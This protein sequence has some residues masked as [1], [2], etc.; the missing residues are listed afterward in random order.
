MPKPRLLV[1]SRM[2]PAL[3]ARTR[4]LCEALTSSWAVL[5]IAERAALGEGDR[6]K[7][8]GFP[9]LNVDIWFKEKR[10][11]VLT[12]LL[13]VLQLNVCALRVA[14]RWRCEVIVCND[15]PYS[16]AG[17]LAKWLLK[18]ELVY[19][20]HEILWGTNCHRVWL[21]LF[22]LLERVVLWNSTFWMA[23][24][25]ARRDLVMAK[26]KVHV[27]CV[28]YENYPVF[29][30]CDE[31][32]RS[33]IPAILRDKGKRSEWVVILQGTLLPDRGIEELL[34]ACEGSDFSVVL[35]GPGPLRSRLKAM[36]HARVALLPACPNEEAVQWFKEA[37]LAFVYYK[38][39]C[40]NSAYACSSKLYC[41][42]FAEVPVVCN[43]LPAFRAFSERYGG[44]AM[45]RDNS[46]IEISR[47]VTALR[48]DADWYNRLVQ[49]MRA[50]KRI[51]RSDARSARIR[52]AFVEM[53]RPSSRR[54]RPVHGCQW[55][56][57]RLHD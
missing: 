49:E 48:Q 34:Q 22:R 1:V 15:A 50:A 30:G 3:N 35:Q 24:S 56:T 18:A 2:S 27:P 20:A 31:V 14:W 42:A 44:L 28:V 5:A 41:A 55:P 12:G 37:D 4:V 32:S 16:V 43:D 54:P 46:P 57:I 33:S 53:L 23:P 38:N 10:L 25:E 11:W 47:V 52:H 7:H 29:T 17:L 8:L 45:V 51:F 39:D 13:R 36:T 21:W 6:P 26:Q 40:L 9:V 19:N